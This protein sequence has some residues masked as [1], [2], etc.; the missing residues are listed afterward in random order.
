MPTLPTDAADKTVPA[1]TDLL[2][3]NT[4]TVEQLKAL[5]GNS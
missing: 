3:I 1:E 5:P 2:D 4:A